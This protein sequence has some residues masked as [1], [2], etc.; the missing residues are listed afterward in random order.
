MI[1]YGFTKTLDQ[2]FDTVCQR[3]PAVLQEHGFGVISRIDM[4]AKFKEKLGV[5]FGKYMIFGACNPPNAYQAV[6]AEEF[7]GLMLPCNVIAFE[8]DGKTAVGAIKPSVAMA[9]VENEEL[10]KVA[11]KVEEDLRGVIEDL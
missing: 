6:Q 9:V 1:P 8:K 5:E 10:G 7:I 3:L 4:S 2:D 11:M